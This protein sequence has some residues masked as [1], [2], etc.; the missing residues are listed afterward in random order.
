M[1]KAE[2]L[3]ALQDGL[4]GLPQDEIRDRLAFY[5]EM[6]DDRMEEGL[7]EAEAVA[8]IGSVDETVSQIVADIPLT[9]LVRE[10]MAPKRTLR[11]WEIIL[12]VLGFPLW[13]P[14]LIAAAAVVFSLYI[15]LWSLIV[16]LWAVVVSLWAAALGGIA[17]AAILAVQ[18]RVPAAVAMLGAGLLCAGLSILM[19][20]GSAAAS[21]GLIHLTKKLAGKIKTL[22]I[23]K[24]NTK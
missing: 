18:G 9:K 2:F 20:S 16:S 22:F 5:S 21:K 17:A 4:A 23:R 10:R 11:A 19:F 24:E 13:F 15:V 3:A 8:G 6:I 1:S 14:L 12:L 7:T